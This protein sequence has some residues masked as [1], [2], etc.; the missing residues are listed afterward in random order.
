MKRSQP[1]SQAVL[2]T[3]CSSGVGQATAV[4]LLRAGYPVYATARRPETLAGLVEAGAVGL[5][6]DVTDAESRAAAVKR[7]EADH[8]AIGILVNNAAYGLQG[9][10]EAVPLEQVRAQFETNVFGVIAMCQL[11]LPAMRAQRWGRIVNLSSMG[12]HFTLP[13]GGFLHATKHAVEAVSDALR[14][15]TGPFGIAVSVVEPGPIRGTAFGDTF[16]GTLPPPDG[17][18]YDQFHAD[19]AARV[20]AAYEPK[21]RNLTLTPDAVARAVE[22]AVRSSRPHPRYPVGAMARGVILLSRIL[23]DRG[24][25]AVIRAMFPVP[26]ASASD[27]DQT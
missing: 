14:L 7:V 19:A 24:L 5:A 3:G 12:G 25:D 21:R 15:E 4:R 26:R 18:P 27:Y 1:V 17:G 9:A 10:V 23:P 22:R 6:L 8:G 20:D 11:A 2:I 13:G 16:N